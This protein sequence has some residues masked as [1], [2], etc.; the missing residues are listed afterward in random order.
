M[1]RRMFLALAGSAAVAAAAGVGRASAAEPAWRVTTIPL[2]MKAP[3][4]LAVGPDG[5]IYVAGE[6]VVMMLSADGQA[7][8]RFAV[9]GRPGCLAIT[10]DGRLLAGM[11]GHVEVL[12]T[13]GSKAGA[14]PDLG[15]RAWLTSIACD[16]ENVY[17]AD[18][19]NRIVWRFDG[20]GKM[21]NRIG[22]KFIVPSP[23]FDVAINP[24]GELW[25]V[26]PGMHGLENYRPGGDLVSSWRR[27]GIEPDSFCGCCN[28]IHIAFRTDNSLVTAEKG[29]ARI[30]VY[31]PDTTLLEVV[32]APAAGPTQN[33]ATLGCNIEAAVADLAVDGKNRI[34]VLNKFEKAILVYE[35]PA[36]KGAA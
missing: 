11:R 30:K 20:C 12:K 27:P 21:L 16:E 7:R 31:S 9:P 35:Q 13:D 8:L 36:E 19:G 15:D 22:E 28:P 24:I 26:N 18:A 5:A 1:K 25:V 3:S 4:A 33:S 29:V 34:L 10:P 14:W 32:A 6:D 2:D 23:Y 17:V